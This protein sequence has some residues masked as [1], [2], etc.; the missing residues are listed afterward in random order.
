MPWL[1]VKCRC[2]C[3]VCVM[4]G[5]G[6]LSTLCLLI[7]LSF[8]EIRRPVCA[9][10]EYFTSIEKHSSTDRSPT[11]T[12]QYIISVVLLNYTQQKLP[13]VNE[14]QKPNF[15][16]TIWPAVLII[17]ALHN[18]VNNNLYIYFRKKNIPSSR[19]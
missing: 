16:T 8:L 5:I 13:K 6:L 4:A 18:V 12:P 7:D 3:R 9:S 14:P 10:K 2:F 17:P 19:R 11:S 1:I 15:K